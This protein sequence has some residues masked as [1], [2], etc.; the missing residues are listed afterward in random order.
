MADHHNSPSVS[1]YLA[2]FATL[3]ILTAATVWAAFQQFGAFNDVVAMGI[4]CTKALV[5]IIF[6]MHVKYSSRLLWLF[7]A[8]GF[9][10]LLIMFA[11]MLTDYLSRDWLGAPS[12]YFLSI[13]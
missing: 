7:V 2:V 13:Q 1:T 9:I 10:F 4:A 12:S 5:V 6:F 8:A 3:M 11:F